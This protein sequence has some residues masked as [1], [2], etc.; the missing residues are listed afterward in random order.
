[1]WVEVWTFFE[2]PC[3][4]RGTR[5]PQAD[6]KARGCVDFL[7]ASLWVF[8]I[9]CTRY[10]FTHTE[11]STKERTNTA[12]ISQQVHIPHHLYS[13]LHRFHPIPSPSHLNPH[14]HPQ[15]L[16]SP[17][18]L[19]NILSFPS[20][21]SP[22]R[23]SQF[24]ILSGSIV[25]LSWICLL[26]LGLSNINQWYYGRPLFSSSWRV[27][28]AL[29]AHIE[30]LPFELS[31]VLLTFLVHISYVC[32]RECVWHKHPGDLRK[33]YFAPHK[34]EIWTWSTRRP[35]LTRSTPIFFQKNVSP[36]WPRAI[37]HYLHKGDW[38]WG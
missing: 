26:V 28:V 24:R 19:R 5:C 20:Q 12:I 38:L 31:K 23:N 4:H 3:I 21:H 15:S 17:S 6:R 8:H 7:W 14:P 2:T 32:V 9:K 16:L 29:T 36:W 27:R 11:K 1:M 37:L 33:P 18:P 34:E 30:I 25:S 22:S 10:L 35:C 13:Q